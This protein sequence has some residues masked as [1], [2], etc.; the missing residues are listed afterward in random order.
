M[1]MTSSLM[2]VCYSCADSLS[3]VVLSALVVTLGDSELVT[4]DEFTV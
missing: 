3:S 4:C 2:K 1:K